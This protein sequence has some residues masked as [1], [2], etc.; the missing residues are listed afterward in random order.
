MSKVCVSK[1]WFWKLSLPFATTSDW[2][3]WTL[4][5]PTDEVR[6]K[7]LPSVLLTWEVH[8]KAENWMEVTTFLLTCEPQA[9]VT[10]KHHR[11]F[12]PASTTQ[13]RQ[14]DLFVWEIKSE[15][16]SPSLYSL[17]AFECQLYDFNV[18]H[19][20]TE[21][22]T[23][24]SSHPP[25]STVRSPLHKGTRVTA[26]QPSNLE[27][28]PRSVLLDPPFITIS[29]LLIAKP[30]MSLNTPPV[31]ETL[32]TEVLRNILRQLAS[33]ED[34]YSTIRASPIAFG[35]FRCFREAILIEV[36]EAHLPAEI[37]A[38]F[39]GLLHIPKY[40]DF[41]YVPGERYVLHVSKKSHF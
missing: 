1:V 38:E 13:T 23:L 32:P 36:L 22:L 12:L 11:C 15:L 40:E 2:E 37:F 41:N 3:R 24:H 39:L 29:T 16:L 30:A 17:L 4:K 20:I 34:L 35:S 7:A 5:C 19:L 9:V 28:G 18:P 27:V 10:I 21:S 25:T 8:C 33:P 26:K 14:R 31:F 6:N